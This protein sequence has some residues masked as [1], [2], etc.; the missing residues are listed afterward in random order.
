MFR[1]RRLIILRWIAVNLSRI[2]LSAELVF[3]GAV[4]IIDPRGTEY[5]IADYSAA[6]H[7]TSLTPTPVPLLLSVLIGALEFCMGVYLLFGV[8]RKFTSRIVLVMM[9]SFTAITL[10]TA[11]TGTVLD[12][13]CFGDA[14]KLTPWQTFAKNVIILP[15]AVMLAMWPRVQARLISITNQWIVAM[16]SWVYAFV[17]AV[18][19][20][21]TIPLMDFRPYH[22]GADL[23]QK[24][25][26]KDDGTQPEIVDLQ[27]YEPRTYRDL[28]DSIIST[29][30]WKFLIISP[31]LTQADDGVMDKLAELT[32]YCQEQDYMLACLTQSDNYEIEQWR[33]ITGAEYPFC[34]VDE[35]VLKTIVR[36]NPGLIMLDGAQIKGKW[37]A[38]QL[39][40]A[41]ELTGPVPDTSL[42]AE[43]S[44]ASHELL[45]LLL[46]FILPLAVISLGDRILVG[47]QFYRNN[48]EKII[49]QF[50]NKK[51]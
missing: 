44:S 1:D 49:N 42:V 40:G 51:K 27:I 20:I 43:T 26:W 45:S 33:E 22:I 15:C 35:V 31:R 4:K 39:P 38:S 9:M 36:S 13:G 17:L 25:T 37:A 8:R 12:C 28:T 34:I 14:V 46:W 6:F 19:T 50:K 24:T 32:D 3:S 7:L 48:R 21:Y 11:L 18:Y 23:I 5:K 10:Y 2:I 47:I 29:P 41:H 16:Y 30:G